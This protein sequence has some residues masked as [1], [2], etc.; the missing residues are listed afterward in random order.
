MN[1]DLAKV[2]L[3]G[4]AE[5][6]LLERNGCNDRLELHYQVRMALR[7]VLPCSW[8][9]LTVRLRCRPKD[10]ARW[11]WFW[12]AVGHAQGFNLGDDAG[13]PVKLDIDFISTCPFKLH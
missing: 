7:N 1:G 8:L 2:R 6:L 5:L 11:V 3:K 13:L 10:S 9:L 12:L 4:R